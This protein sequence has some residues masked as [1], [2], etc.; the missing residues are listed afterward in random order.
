MRMFA[1]R[2]KKPLE[3][4]GTPDLDQ[5]TE[6][7]VICPHRPCPFYLPLLLFLSLLSG[8]VKGKVEVAERRRCVKALV[9]IEHGW[10]LLAQTRQLP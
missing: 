10:T 7:E 5:D 2:S 4:L 1:E 6:T 3:K 8:T 9:R